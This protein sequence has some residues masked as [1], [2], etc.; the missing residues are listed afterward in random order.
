MEGRRDAIVIANGKGGVGKTTLTANLA[1]Q[2]AL[3]TP[4]RVLALDLDAQGNLATA[5]G[6]AD[7]AAPPAAPG[8]IP[9]GRERLA[10]AAW[11]LPEVPAA[12]ADALRAGL[13]GVAADLAF[14]DT[15]PSATSP[16]ADAALAVARWL[17]IP[18]RCDRHS[19]DGIATLLRRA[20]AAGDGRIQPLGIV[21]F[22]VQARAT[23]ILADTRADLAERLGG[24]IHVFDATIRAAE[25]AQIDALDA[26]LTAAEYGQLAALQGPWYESR[27][28]IR[29]AGNADDL[30]GDYTRLTGE[31]GF[32]WSVN[33]NQHR[34]GTAP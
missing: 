23:R 5:L 18:A 15:P 9:T 8:T 32:R 7:G 24:A 17:L 16:L 14:I 12:A 10:Y 31:V 25:R 19:I 34:T 6:L 2:I 3:H 1:A 27:D 33:K 21:L 11:D 30:A 26:G 20:I 28:V 29:L 13:D 4:R 22:A